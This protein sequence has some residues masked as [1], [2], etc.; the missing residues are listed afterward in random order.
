MGNSDLSLK[1][2]VW[3][4]GGGGEEASPAPP[5]LDETLTARAKRYIILSLGTVFGK[6]RTGSKYKDVNMQLPMYTAVMK[7]N[8]GIA[9]QIRQ[10]PLNSEA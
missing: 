5:S 10:L 3:G 9:K 8:Q 6:L 1:I 2:V 7:Q 4:G